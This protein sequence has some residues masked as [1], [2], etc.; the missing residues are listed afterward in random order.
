MIPV[1]N[2]ENHLIMVIQVE[3]KIESVVNKIF[4]QSI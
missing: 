1:F 3:S 4:K 2:S